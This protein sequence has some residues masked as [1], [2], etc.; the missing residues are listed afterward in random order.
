M[1]LAKRLALSLLPLTLAT[2]AVA[3]GGAYPKRP[4]K[5]IVGFSAGGATDVSARLYAKKMGDLLGQAVIVENKLGAAG[6]LSAEYV[7]RSPNDGYTL[8]YTSSSIHGISPHIYPN[9]SWDPIKDF[10]PIALAA[11][12]PQALVINND[13]PAKTLPELIALI[14]KSPGTFS[15]ASAGK[16]G[17]QHLAAAMLNVQAKTDMVHIPYKGMSAAYPDLM[18]GRVQLMFDN[19]PS[20]MPFISGGKVRGLAVS[21]ANRVSIMPNIPTVAE[22]GFPKFDVVAWAGFVAPAGTPQPIIDKVNDAVRKAGQSPEVKQW[23]ID[24]GSPT[25]LGSTPAEFGNFL[26]KELAFWKQAVDA[27]GAKAD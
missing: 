18:A 16:G 23:L 7:A 14:K 21:S 15:Y 13:V 19:S 2:T 4:I 12:F 6:T 3:Q 17:T 9:L 25:D 26:Q 8:L 20:A 1:K 5:L 10:A 22:S 27:S 24:N 11:K